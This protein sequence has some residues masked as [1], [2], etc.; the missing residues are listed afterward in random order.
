M[1]SLELSVGAQ[2]SQF[3]FFLQKGCSLKLLQWLGFSGRDCPLPHWKSPTSCSEFLTYWFIR[4]TSQ[5]NRICHDGICTGRPG[6]RSSAGAKVFSSSKCSDQ[7]EGTI[8]LLFNKYRGLLPR[9]Q[10]SRG[11]NLTTH[12]H[13]LQRIRMVAVVPLPL[14]ICI[15][16]THSDKFT[17][18][19][20]LCDTIR[21][22]NW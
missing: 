16:G 7:L 5:I 14:P 10:D 13:R 9:G 18:T 8:S 2:S 12:V 3:F 15:R 21:R 4:K 22:L 11:V 17:F 6:V 19:F 1:L 20:A